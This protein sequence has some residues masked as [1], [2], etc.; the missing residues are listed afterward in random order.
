MSNTDKHFVNGNPIEGPFPD[1]LQQAVFGMG[2]F[3]GAERRFWE[4]PG[5]WSTA[6]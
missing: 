6:V 5:V 3:W 4:T 1:G 2:S